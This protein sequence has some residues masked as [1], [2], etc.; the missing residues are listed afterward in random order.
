VKPNGTYDWLDA[1][2]GDSVEPVLRG[3]GIREIR[4]TNAAS[5][6]SPDNAIYA[7]SIPDSEDAPHQARDLKYYLRVNGHNYPARHRQIEDIR[8]RRRN[9]KVEGYI[10]FTVSNLERRTAGRRDRGFASAICH[11]TNIGGVSTRGA[12]LIFSY[13]GCEG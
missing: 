10:E 2:I 3:Y 13:P 8:G 9:P 11:L 5:K 4:A 1:L 12:A 6:I 7:V